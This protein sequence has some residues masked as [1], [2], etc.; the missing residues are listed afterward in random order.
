MLWHV[1]HMVSGGHERTAN[2]FN[3]QPKSRTT[4]KNMLIDRSEQQKKFT[5]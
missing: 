5:G 1:I 3:T 4:I 2:S